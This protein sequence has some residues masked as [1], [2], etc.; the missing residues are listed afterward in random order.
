MTAAV[1]LEA[2]RALLLRAARTL[3]A[4]LLGAWSSPSALAAR[5]WIDPVERREILVWLRPLEVFARA[6]LLDF[7]AHVRVDAAD[8]RAPAG[9]REAPS[10][11]A[12]FL[13]RRRAER[14]AGIGRLGKAQPPADSADWRIRFVLDRRRSG[15]GRGGVRAGA[16]RER[17][18]ALRYARRLEAAARVLE[19]P[20]G[21]AAWLAGRRRAPPSR[22]SPQAEEARAWVAARKR[23]IVEENARRL[24]AEAEALNSS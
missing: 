11:P 23:E 3:L 1:D 7:A 5:G 9:R 4:R 18:D 6:L 10:R 16:A 19:D 20:A 2:Y 22:G 17:Y 8:R 13:A 15:W 14:A 21:Y 12:W 24:L